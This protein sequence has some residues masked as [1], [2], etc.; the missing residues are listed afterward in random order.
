MPEHGSHS[1]MAKWPAQRTRRSISRLDVVAVLSLLLIVFLCPPRAASQKVTAQV[2]SSGQTLGQLV[3]D[4]IDHEI[5]AQAND[6]SLWCYRKLQEKDGQQQLF[7]ACQAEG[8][9]IDRLVAVN[10]QLLDEK[11]REA[12]Q[13]RIENLLKSQGQL[14]KQAQR[15]HQD[16]RQATALL[17]TIPD[18]FVFQMEGKE[19]DQI[20]L[21][22]APNPKF[23]PWGH[24]AQV[25]HH[26]EG[27]LVLDLKQK[28]LAEISGRL[29]SAVKFGGGLL[30]H[31]DKGGTFY[32]KQQEVGSGCWEMT[33]L[34]VEM[35]GKALFFK[36]IAV[37]EKETDT[38][39][40]AVPQSA[41]IRQAAGMTK[42]KNT[43]VAVR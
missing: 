38:E 8:A 23:H 27:T 6:K 32:V 24:E 35:N 33:T 39:F 14:K 3:R 28:R 36:T 15:Q 40:R 7:T 22:F 13:E 16:A 26:M 18:A 12:E 17:K 21:K 19:G 37:R 42:G 11:Q 4:T 34:D 25:F 9:E 29:T 30:G 43:E 41:T 20:K 10:G 31:L 5:D 1:G 2:E